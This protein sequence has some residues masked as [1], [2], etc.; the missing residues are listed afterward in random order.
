MPD[1]KHMI[2][3]VEAARI[4]GITTNNLNQRVHRGL[5]VPPAIVRIGTAVVYDRRRIEQLAASR[6]TRSGGR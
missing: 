4:L 6:A 5:I 2:D 1:I 3:G